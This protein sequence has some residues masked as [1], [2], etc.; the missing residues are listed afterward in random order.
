MIKAASETMESK[1]TIGTLA[2]VKITKVLDQ[3]GDIKIALYDKLRRS[4]KIHSTSC[5]GDVS[6]EVSPPALFRCILADPDTTRSTQMYYEGRKFVRANLVPKNDFTGN[7]A[8]IVFHIDPYQSA[9]IERIVT[10]I[11]ERF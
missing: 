2:T 4:V 6:I 9:D 8:L 5:A 11:A 1:M 10:R 3:D 7:P